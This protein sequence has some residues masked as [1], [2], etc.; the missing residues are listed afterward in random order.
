MARWG[1]FIRVII[2][3]LAFFLAYSSFVPFAGSAKF[4]TNEAGF[5]SGIIHGTL[6]P[7]MLVAYFFTDFGVY[8]VNSSWGY[9]FGFIVSL[10]FIWGGSGKSSKNVIKNYYKMPGSKSEK[11]KSLSEDDH[12]HIGNIIEEK[13]KALTSKKDDMKETKVTNIS[14]SKKKKK[15][16]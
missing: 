7:G 3:V 2:L 9:A 10:L 14:V 15:K 11:K 1:F 13:I 16:K 6:A 12:A 4:L 5:L 8:E